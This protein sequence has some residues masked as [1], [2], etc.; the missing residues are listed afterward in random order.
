MSVEVTQGWLLIPSKLIL[1]VGFLASNNLT[2]SLNSSVNLLLVRDPAGFRPL[3]NDLCY[4][5]L[6]LKHL[7]RYVRT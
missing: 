2:R 5:E 3:K 6:K 1:S 4:A 7:R